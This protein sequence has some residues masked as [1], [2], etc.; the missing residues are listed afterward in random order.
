MNIFF[1]LWRE[2]ENTETNITHMLL[3]VF[4]QHSFAS[5]FNESKSFI[6]KV[7]L[8]AMLPTVIFRNFAPSTLDIRLFPLRSNLLQGWFIVE[9]RVDKHAYTIVPCIDSL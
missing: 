4:N 7:I 9:L 8:D 5:H 2:L 3:I 1:W 6:E